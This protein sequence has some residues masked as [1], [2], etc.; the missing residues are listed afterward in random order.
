MRRRKSTIIRLLEEGLA[1]RERM[2]SDFLCWAGTFSLLFAASQIGIPHSETIN[3]PKKFPTIRAA[4]AAAKDGDTIEVENGIYPEEKIIIDSC[5]RL[6]SRNLYGA[7]IY[8]TEKNPGPIFI[9][10]A[11]AEI[12][13]FVLKNAFTGIEQRDSPGVRW[14]GHDLVFLG[15]WDS[16]V[17]INAVTGNVGSARLNNII[18]D[19][20]RVGIQTND[21]MGVEATNCLIVNCPVA[22]AGFDHL[23]FK[24][25]HT[26]II[27]CGTLYSEGKTPTGSP[28]TNKIS[29]GP[30]I[31]VLDADRHEWKNENDRFSSPQQNYDLEAA[32]EKD[33]R[34]RDFRDPFTFVV[35]GDIYAGQKEYSR[36]A[37][38]YRQALAAG[39]AKNSRQVVCDAYCRLAR[40]CLTGGNRH[41]SL[42]FYKKAIAAVEQIGSDLPQQVYK[43]GFC[44]EKMKIYEEIVSLLLEMHEKEPGSGYD[45]DAF[46]YAER[47]KR[48]GFLESL[49]GFRLGMQSGFSRDKNARAIFLEFSRIQ[50]ELQ[51]R[52]LGES[53]RRGLLRELEAQE[54]KYRSLMAEV[55][56]RS[57]QPST[58]MDSLD[59]GYQQVEK[60]LTTGDTALLEFMLGEKTSW[61]FLVTSHGL[62]TTV[63]PDSQTLA[64]LVQNYLTFIGLSPKKPGDFRAKKG[65]ER[66]FRLLIGSFGTRLG[67]EVKR[68]FIVPDGILYYL[69]FETLVRPIKKIDLSGTQAERSNPRYLIEDYE[70]SYAPSAACLI[71]LRER[72]GDHLGK[73]DLLAVANAEGRTF[74]NPSTGLEYRLPK[75]ANVGEEIDAVA[76]FFP[77]A[78]ETILTRR[79]AQETKFKEAPLAD[80]KIIHLATH[81]FYDE[82]NW[83]R[84]ALMLRRN[85]NSLE[86]GL[87]QPLEISHLDLNADLVVLSSCEAGRGEFQEGEGIL[88]FSMAFM[89]SGARSVVTS[90][91]N[92]NDSSTA[93]FM[94][95]FYRFLTEGKNKAQALRLSK[96]RMINSPFKHPYYWG[97]F[98]LIGDSVS[99]LSIENRS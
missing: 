30:D 76:A 54:G 82:V 37:G 51:K 83:W 16:A 56:Q 67:P 53:E 75:L 14:E 87:L 74:R 93:R 57:P 6:R 32:S 79:D 85:R 97:T 25:D 41:G 2:A 8:G 89:A 42:K 77:P 95:F 34:L 86:D 22:F 91:W 7:V 19:N 65:G 31:V 36:A 69:P 5:I 66:L 73:M 72:R 10:R 3:V 24:V 43:S 26:T 21:A 49:R 70:I 4:V 62:S 80:F 55:G 17:S 28:A 1:G 61:A 60:K 99:Y 68:L 18:V 52:H 27:N 44:K 48:Q 33:A 45:R 38:F 23:Y 35:L 47:S 12:D 96:I 81:G 13:G 59:D 84:S 11:K 9:I 98:V 29:L 46:A 40:V 64:A 63:L 20:C 90:L 78:R 71:N 58:L 15:M 88:G 50:N 39:Q 94:G 92:V